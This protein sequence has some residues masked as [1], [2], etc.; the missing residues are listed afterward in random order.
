MSEEK[1]NVSIVITD[2][3][4]YPEPSTQSVI[5]PRIQMTKEEM[6]DYAAQMEQSLQKNEIA[7]SLCAEMIH[8]AYN[9]HEVCR[10]MIIVAD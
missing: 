9:Q 4:V 8:I 3:K 6:K 1:S 2:N 7:G 10:Y 5:N